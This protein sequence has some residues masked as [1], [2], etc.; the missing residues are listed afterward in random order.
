MIMSTSSML[1][2]RSFNLDIT[3]NV[4]TTKATAT[5]AIMPRANSQ[6]FSDTTLAMF[7]MS[8]CSTVQY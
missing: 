5:A 2:C 7:E 8:S 1:N 6:P 3:L 4:S